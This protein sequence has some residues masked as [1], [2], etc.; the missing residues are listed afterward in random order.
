M[1]SEGGPLVAA[2]LVAALGG[3]IT[4][5]PWLI[6]SAVLFMALGLASFPGARRRGESSA[7]APAE[8]ARSS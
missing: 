3:L 2:L 6:V 8:R 7:G 5:Q 4:V 1:L